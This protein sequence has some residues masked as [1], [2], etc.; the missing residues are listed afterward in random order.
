MTA[1]SR[2]RKRRF[3]EQIREQVGAQEEIKEGPTKKT[4]YEKISFYR[5]WIVFFGNI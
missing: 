5:C 2:P 4:E 3:R 1:F